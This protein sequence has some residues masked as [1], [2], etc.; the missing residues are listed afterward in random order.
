MGSGVRGA[1]EE[2][3][4]EVRGGG[5]NAEKGGVSGERRGEER[6]RGDV[7]GERWREPGRR[8]CEAMLVAGGGAGERLKRGVRR[9]K[10][11]QR[12]VFSLRRASRC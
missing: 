5:G 2:G 10:G 6:R 12:V 11:V 3:G 7:R 1:A 8:G 9:E 4:A